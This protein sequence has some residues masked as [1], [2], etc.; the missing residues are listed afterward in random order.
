[1][2]GLT[3]DK[4]FGRTAVLTSAAS[5]IARVLGFAR[6]VSL[7]AAFGTALVAD[8]YNVAN[9]IPN[10]IFFLLGGGTLG[11]MLVPPLV[12]LGHDSLRFNRLCVLIIVGGATAGILGSATLVLLRVPLFSIF[13]GSSWQP[14]QTQLAADLGLWCL[15]QFAFLVLSMLL[16]QILNASGH[17]WMATWTPAVN[18]ICVIFSSVLILLAAPIGPNSPGAVDE[19]QI[20][21]LGIGTLAGSATQFIILLAGCLTIGIR[22]TWRLDPRA[23]GLRSIVKAGLGILSIGFMSQVSNLAIV[24]VTSR[25][26][27][28]ASENG[29]LGRGYTAYLYP[30]V[31]VSSVQAVLT[32]SI[33]MILLQRLSLKR[34]NGQ[35]L[36]A[37]REAGRAIGKCLLILIPASALM[38]ATSL[39][40]VGLIFGFGAVSND[41]SRSLGVILSIMSLG[42]VPYAMQPVL[43]RPFFAAGDNRTPIIGYV[44]VYVTQGALSIF[45]FV[46]SQ[47]SLVVFLCAG[48]FLVAY[49]ID[50]PLKF[51]RLRRHGLV[52]YRPEDRTLLWKSI[53]GG[54]AGAAAGTAV[55]VICV[56]NIAGANGYVASLVT[57]GFITILLHQAFTYRTEASVVTMLSIKRHSKAEWVI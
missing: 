56:T 15:P 43:V 51:L 26:G 28:L 53:R 49:W 33:A 52:Q 18:S 22:W 14:E 1:M 24:V 3:D 47:A 11:A 41:M 10:T 57:G 5:L 45:A 12:R 48:A 32:A 54:F 44:L 16:T 35:H 8:S 13:G 36:D 31:I 46:I 55:A 2:P 50:L 30:Y 4:D 17:F 29:V 23:L 27:A 20:L 6:N 21:I 40:M 7:A 38:V 19:R 9:T 37:A 39:P 42:L 25:A 34:A